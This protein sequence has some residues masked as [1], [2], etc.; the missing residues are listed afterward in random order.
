MDQKKLFYEW[1]PISSQQLQ[2]HRPRKM[3]HVKYHQNA[4]CFGSLFLEFFSCFFATQ[5]RFRF[6]IDNIRWPET[7]KQKKQHKVETRRSINP[8]D[9]FLFS[10]SYWRKELDF[11]LLFSFSWERMK[12]A[13]TVTT[14]PLSSILILSFSQ[15]DKVAIFFF[16]YF[17]GLFLFLWLV[18]SFSSILFDFLIVYFSVFL[19]L[20]LCPKRQWQW[21]CFSLLAF[22]GFH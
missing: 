9:T 11:P 5:K 3:F 14:P 2:V 15:Y 6:S 8:G 20:Y 19:L 22:Y 1:P 12:A 17:L 21:L 16:I 18:P 4:F 10:F 13:G 7:E